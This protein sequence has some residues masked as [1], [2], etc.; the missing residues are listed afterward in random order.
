MFRGKMVRKN[1]ILIEK[2]DKLAPLWLQ[3][4]AINTNQSNQYLLLNLR[5]N[6]SPCINQLIN[7][8]F[9]LVPEIWV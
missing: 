9:L 4:V 5:L 2:V 3:D 7:N 1:T 8:S 6:N